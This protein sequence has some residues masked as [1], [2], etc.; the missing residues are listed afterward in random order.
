[1]KKPIVNLKQVIN[2]VDLKRRVANAF[3][4][5]G[6]EAADAIRDLLDEL[7]QSKVEVDEDALAEKIREVLAAEEPSPKVEEAIANAIAKRV[8]QITNT[9]KGKDLSAAV[10]NQISAA[11]L[12]A[13]SKE[14]VK[15]AVN[16]V[17]VKNDI[18]GLTFEEVVD[19]A[20]VESWGDMNP[21]FKQLHK[22]MFTKFFYTESE[23][24]TMALLAKQWDKTGEAEKKIQE[25]AA[26]GKQILTKYI[27]KRQRAA[28]EDLDEIEKVGNLPNF[29]RFIDEELDRMIVNTIVLAILVGDTVNDLADRVTTFETIGTKNVSDLFTTV[30][31]PEGTQIELTDLRALCDSV[32]NPYGKRKVLIINTT[33]LSLISEAN[34][35]EGSKIFYRPKDEIARMLGVDEIIECDLLDAETRED[36]N[37]GIFA[38]CMLP[39]G[40]WY[41]E[42]KA[43]A[44]AY[45]KY[46]ENTMN[47]QKERNIG[48]AIHDLYS[49]AVLKRGENVVPRKGAKGA[50]GAKN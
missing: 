5:R 39:E 49:T 4:E 12:R 10:K 42:K 38:I 36:E 50:K 44:V 24:K 14:D 18:S 43:L 40:Y 23:L 45:P 26:I 9:V 17:L 46:E 29:L 47:Y 34:Y 11:I 21:I 32:K 7:E 3:S 30:R 37:D 22:T 27:Y 31:V 20:I 35:A 8:A 2:F 19:Y 28:Q 25:F 6:K 15:N 41:N 48:G 1:M 16:A 33:T 13:N